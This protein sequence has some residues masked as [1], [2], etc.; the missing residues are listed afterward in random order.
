MLYMRSLCWPTTTKLRLFRSRTTMMTLFGES[1]YSTD[2]RLLRFIF[3][4]LTSLSSF[5]LTWY[6]GSELNTHKKLLYIIG[7]PCTA[8]LVYTLEYRIKNRSIYTW[9]CR[10]NTNIWPRIPS[11]YP[12]LNICLSLPHTYTHM[13]IHACLLDLLVLTYVVLIMY[14]CY[15]QK[16]SLKKLCFSIHIHEL[17][18]IHFYIHTYL[19][20][21]ALHLRGESMISRRVQQY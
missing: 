10:L 6:G 2:R 16:I 11:W 3:L 18:L 5:T 21:L 8:V 12:V 17:Y 20:A 1:P 4:S 14:L 19:P 15:F 13:H 7:S 9:H